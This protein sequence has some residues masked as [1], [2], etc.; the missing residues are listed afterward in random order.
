MRFLRHCFSQQQ[1]SVVEK[2]DAIVDG[3]AIDDIDIRL[4]RLGTACIESG[5]DPRLCHKIWNKLKS[6]RSRLNLDNGIQLLSLTVTDEIIGETRRIPFDRFLT[7]FNQI[8]MD[9]KKAM[10]TIGIDT[11]ELMKNQCG[12]GT[13]KPHHIRGFYAL[14]MCTICKEKHPA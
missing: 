3:L 1:F 12:M 8:D 5:H 7:Q 14:L 4:T 10:K 9:E 6:S 13:M 11:K 2:K